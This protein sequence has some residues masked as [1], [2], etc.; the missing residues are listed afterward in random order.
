MKMIT[1]K[2][3][4]K[5]IFGLIMAITGVLV[6]VISFAS[7]HNGV[8]P[9]NA[10]AEISCATAKERSEYI[11]SLGWETDGSEETKEITIPQQFNKVY[12]DYNKI[13]K[14][15]GF[16]LE[17]HKGKPATIYT[18]NITNYKEN[19]NVIADLIVQDGVLIGA[20]LCDT[21]VETGFLVALNENGQN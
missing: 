15:Q 9:S 17:K 1:L 20:D 8:V 3:N 4:P 16:D 11:S 18:Y 21:N 19:K 10:K 12:T 5:T 14:K 13:Q 2:A 7:N 6:I